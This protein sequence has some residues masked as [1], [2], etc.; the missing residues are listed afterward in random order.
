MNVMPINTANFIAM[1]C[2]N[3]DSDKIT[4]AEFRKFARELLVDVEKPP[5][6]QFPGLSEEVALR[7]WGKKRDGIS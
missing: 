1:L 7:Y 2:A 5:L 6:E 4:D 3:A